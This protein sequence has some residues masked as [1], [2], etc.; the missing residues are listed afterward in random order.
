MTVRHL[1]NRSARRAFT[2]VEVLVIISIIMLLISMLLPALARHKENARRI[3]CGNNLRQ[4]GL[5]CTEYSDDHREN[6]PDVGGS[7]I[8]A[9]QF[10][11]TLVRRILEPYGLIQEMAFCIDGFIPEN[12]QAALYSA[13]GPQ[14]W[15]YSYFPNRDTRDGLDWDRVPLNKLKNR[16]RGT[17]D[18]WVLIADINTGHNAAAWTPWRPWA[19]SHANHA[20]PRR[21]EGTHLDTGK[22]M[23]IPHG[24]NNCYFDTHVRWISFDS[25]NL[26]KKYVHSHWKYNF[27]WD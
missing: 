26:T 19:I 6:F 25:L 22:Q 17:G 18:E 20:N 15:G 13:A 11:A 12:Q 3:I 16:I 9:F 2:L 5:M 24:V 27:H 4:W 7:P 23:F 14:F 8:E 10:D 21:P 1:A